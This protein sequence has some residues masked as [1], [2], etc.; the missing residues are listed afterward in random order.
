MAGDNFD[1][2]GGGPNS[3]RVQMLLTIPENLISVD[4]LNMVW[5]FEN[6]VWKKYGIYL[7]QK[8]KNSANIAHKEYVYFVNM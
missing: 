1:L 4:L 7:D 2:G 8:G 3:P 5:K 6:L